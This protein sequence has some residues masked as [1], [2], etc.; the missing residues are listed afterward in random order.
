MNKKGWVLL[1]EL[2]EDRRNKTIRFTE[3]GSTE[4]KRILSKVR[5]SEQAAMDSLT[6]EERKVLLSATR[7]YI[8][9]CKAAMNGLSESPDIANS[10]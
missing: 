1:E 8:T 7:R 9:G 10:K 6:E 2:P 4:A 3:L 5:Q